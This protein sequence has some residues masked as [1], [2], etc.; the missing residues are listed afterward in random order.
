MSLCISTDWSAEVSAAMEHALFTRLL[1]VAGL[2]LF[3]LL[4]NMTFV[5]SNASVPIQW[6]HSKFQGDE[7]KVDGE[8]SSS[9]KA[10]P[11]SPAR[12]GLLG[13]DKH[14]LSIYWL[15]NEL[16]RVEN[17]HFFSFDMMEKVGMPVN[18]VIVEGNG[19]DEKEWKRHPAPPGPVLIMGFR[20]DSDERARIVHRTG[21][22][23]SGKFGLFI[24]ADE[25]GLYNQ[26]AVDPAYVK[27]IIRPYYHEHQYRDSDRVVYEPTGYFNG[28]APWNPAIL[29]HVH[30]RS[31]DCWFSGSMRKERQ[32]MMDVFK[33][34][35][36]KGLVKCLMEKQEEFAG[37]YSPEFYAFKMQDTKLAFCP[38]G[39]SVETIRLY[40]A[41]ESGAIPVMAQADFD[42]GNFAKTHPGAPF[43]IVPD[44]DEAP[45]IIARWLLPENAAEL[46]QVQ[47]DNISWYQS[48]KNL[49]RENVANAVRRRLM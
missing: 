6:V 7:S 16:V 24:V 12:D 31:V 40:E 43:I 13:D 45:E 48:Y 4:F 23:P 3:L 44:W 5:N 14:V 47:L 19:T 9:N 42:E 8:G 41:W 30:Q 17:W 20:T 18:I 46:K 10:R 22:V 34:A 21:I 28:R 33:A 35:R 38:G 25:S 11:D 26:S 37:G 27:L 2:F 49:I 39:N 32:H 1:L 29:K 36:K 15:R